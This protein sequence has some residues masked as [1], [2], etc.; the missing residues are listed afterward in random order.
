MDE[1]SSVWLKR[2]SYLLLSGSVLLGAGS[3]YARS[4]EAAHDIRYTALASNDA[5]VFNP[6]THS[7]SAIQNGRVIRSGPASGG[8]HFCPDTGRACRTPTGTF[9]VISKGDASCRSSSYPV[10]VGGARM[11]YCMFFSKY[12]AI[13]GY[14]EV[15]NHNASHGCIRIRSSDARWLSHSF[16]KIGTKVIVKSY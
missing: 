9:H 8:K 15:A 13:H 12:Y 3:V 7:W 2:A 14:H 4:F 6:R 16:M 5:F 11:P 10:G 1:S